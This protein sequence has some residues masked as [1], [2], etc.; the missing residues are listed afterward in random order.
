MLRPIV[1][2]L[3]L[4]AALAGVAPDGLEIPDPFGRYSATDRLMVRSAFTGDDRSRFGP[5]L[6]CDVVG[7]GRWMEFEFLSASDLLLAA[8][9]VGRKASDHT[10]EARIH[11]GGK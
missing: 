4:S 8:F 2:L 3:L 1:M 9:G 7:P 10:P 11:K 5:G 6:F